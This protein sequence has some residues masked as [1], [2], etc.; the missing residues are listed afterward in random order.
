MIFDTKF[1]KEQREK[2]QMTDT[3]NKRPAEIQLSK[4]NATESDKATDGGSWGRAPEEVLSERRCVISDRQYITALIFRRI[5]KAQI[6]TDAQPASSETK[7]KGNDP[8]FFLNTYMK[9][10]I[11]VKGFSGYTI[12]PFAAAAM[13]PPV[14][15][16]SPRSPKNNP[17][18]S[19]S[20]TPNP[21]M[22]Y[23]KGN[24]YWS[25][26]PA[27]TTSGASKDVSE[28]KSM[29]FA[30]YSKSAAASTNTDTSTTP[31]VPS[32]KQ[33][34]LADTTEKPDAT[35]STQPTAEGSRDTEES[36]KQ[37]DETEEG[38]GGNEEG[39]QDGTDNSPPVSA[40][41][42]PIAAAGATDNGE[43]S[44]ECVMQL[45]AKLFRLSKRQPVGGG[46]GG[47]PG[48]ASSKATAPQAE[49]VEI[50]TGPVRVLRPRK[51]AGEEVVAGPLSRLVM[52][53]ESQAG[54]VGE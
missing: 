26:F 16:T 8:K 42:S 21:F 46:G 27:T 13:G 23:N 39:E 20:P 4:D 38:A 34:D 31:S 43:G 50:G 17:F 37:T 3:N 24:N 33:P 35:A 48:D 47:E 41:S 19:P 11:L 7:P 10:T 2:I 51:T 30:A 29:G 14:F 52:R 25:K 49:W 22:S 53:R 6:G 18:S 40:P 32:D 54:G 45:R 5:L 36:A 15:K 9:E 1:T 44:E 28:K 12:N